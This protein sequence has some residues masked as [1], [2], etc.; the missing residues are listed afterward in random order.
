MKIMDYA[1]IAIIAVLSVVTAFVGLMTFAPMTAHAKSSNMK[2]GN[3]I[4]QWSPGLLGILGLTGP[5]TPLFTPGTVYVFVV[6]PGNSLYY[7]FSNTPAGS[8][9][10]YSGWIR[11]NGAQSTL[12]IP[13]IFEWPPHSGQIVVFTELADK[14]VGYK[15]VIGPSQYPL[16]DYFN[17]GGTLFSSPFTIMTG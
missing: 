3:L 9:G 10:S 8:P 1:T 2:D 14:T 12:G 5:S 16:T 17:L 13:S 6:G 7:Q 15:F 11:L 4:Q